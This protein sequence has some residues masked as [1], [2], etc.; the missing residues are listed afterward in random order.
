MSNRGLTLTELIVAIVISGIVLL[1]LTCQ[2]VAEQ[3]LQKTIQDQVVATNDA[4]IAVRHMA[5]ILRYA[6]QSTIQLCALPTG[7]YDTSIKATI[8]HDSAGANLPEFTE[9]NT[10]IIYGRKNDNTFEY[11]MGS[12]TYVVSNH[13][14]SFPVTSSSWDSANKNLTVQLIAQQGNESSSLDTK[15][16]VLE[17]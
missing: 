14:T 5:R 15:I 17:I 4:S 1:A 10:Q 8:D 12:T 11:T 13:I 7:G 3:T 2:F 16:H 6:K 9:N